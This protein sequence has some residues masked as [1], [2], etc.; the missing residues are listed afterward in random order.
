MILSFTQL[1]SEMFIYSSENEAYN[2]FKR[3]RGKGDINVAI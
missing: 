3:M 2:L 1:Y